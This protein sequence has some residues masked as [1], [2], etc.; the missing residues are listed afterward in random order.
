MVAIVSDEDYEWLSEFRWYASYRR[1]KRTSCC[2][3]KRNWSDGGKSR[4]EYMHRAIL[5]VS[6]HHT[7]H[8]NGNTLD[9]RRENLRSATASQNQQNRCKLPDSSSEYKG[10]SKYTDD[11]GES[12]RVFIRGRTRRISMSGIKNERIA[13]MIY[14]LLALDSNGDF[15]RLNVPE[16]RELV[17]SSSAPSSGCRSYQPCYTQSG[18]PVSGCGD[19]L[20][21]AS[22]RAHERRGV[23]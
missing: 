7:D 18:T 16:L 10:V 12:W 4:V 20:Q 3:A 6:G 19:N 13:G 22:Q 14:D 8:I 1:M 5:G 17:A 2:Y 23:K 11:T 15:A 21:V 9:N